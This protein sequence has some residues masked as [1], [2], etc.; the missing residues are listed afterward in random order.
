MSAI[1]AEDDLKKL[2]VP[3][4]KAI[5]KQRNIT[6]YS[7]LQKSAIIQKL[8]PSHADSSS[9]SLTHVS[10]IN[11]AFPTSYFSLSS[12]VQQHQH[13]P[14]ESPG[15]TVLQ[16]ANTT[17]RT[18]ESCLPTSTSDLGPLPPSA[19]GRLR[20]E[21]KRISNIEVADKAP[22]KKSKSSALLGKLAGAPHTF[23]SP[24]ATES[25]RANLSAET[26][27]IA[28]PTRKERI[29]DP[30]AQY[31]PGT[32]P[33]AASSIGG[34]NF[35]CAPPKSA[36]PLSNLSSLVAAPEIRVRMKP[37]V[38]PKINAPKSSSSYSMSN[39][40]APALKR[41][42][43]SRCASNYLHF[44]DPPLEALNPITLP[45]LLSQRKVAIG[46]VVIFSSVSR[47]DLYNLAQ[48]SRLF[49]YAGAY[50]ACVKSIRSNYLY[51]TSLH[52]CSSASI[53][54]IRRISNVGFDETILT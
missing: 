28:F 22:R 34:S 44:L 33:T 53:A 18:S 24:T 2:T 21:K 38:P 26:P 36:G 37:F 27:V 9:T 1:L 3:Q 35:L 51:P 31:T 42:V 49:R 5:C 11:T 16:P 30:A 47:Q 7:K 45:P 19:D 12:E 32:N 13:R 20:A 29:S 52:L 41:L 40:V 17:C 46:L 6:G 14:E 50:F 15:G 48:A 43:T 23:S 10:E 4:L 25:T 54:S 8:L 39:L